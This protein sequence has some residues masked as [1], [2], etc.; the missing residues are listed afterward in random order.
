MARVR[1]RQRFSAVLTHNYYR[2]SLGHYPERGKM[3]L[4]CSPA[5]AAYPLM[6]A[7]GIGEIS[8]SGD[9]RG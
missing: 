9:A 4:L 3:L 6:Y 8:V 5:T 1:L 2:L 7:G